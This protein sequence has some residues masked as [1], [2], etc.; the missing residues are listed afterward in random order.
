MPCL[1]RY[2]L[3]VWWVRLHSMLAT[4]SSV[5]SL[6]WSTETMRYSR[7]PPALPRNAPFCS[8]LLTQIAPYPKP[9]QIPYL[10]TLTCLSLYAYPCMSQQLQSLQVH[11]LVSRSNK[12]ATAK[13]NCRYYSNHEVVHIQLYTHS[14]RQSHFIWQEGRF[15]CKSARIFVYLYSGIC[16]RSCRS[17]CLILL[18]YRACLVQAMCRDYYTLQFMDP[19]VDTAP[20][21]PSLAAFF[22]NVLDKSISELNFKVLSLEEDPPS[23]RCKGRERYAPMLRYIMS[24]AG[25]QIRSH[26]FE[27]STLMTCLPVV[28][29][30]DCQKYSPSP[31][32]HLHDM[33]LL[34]LAE[35]KSLLVQDVSPV[36]YC[37]SIEPS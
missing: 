3:Q 10:R 28:R 16:T 35:E 20:I 12:R 1:K 34:A 8:I 18:I 37:I 26:G 4:P 7:L 13:H 19:S 32:H 14:K 27:H 6:I 23:P 5:M 17:R 2:M 30:C 11:M 24:A 33:T 31:G 15:F 25:I 21:A 9:R 36:L 29:Q 22:D